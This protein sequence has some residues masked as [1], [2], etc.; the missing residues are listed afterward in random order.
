MKS[1]DAYIAKMKLQLDELNITIK[2][3]ELKAKLASI[4]TREKYDVEIVKMR[5][6]YQVAL[7]KL[8]ELKLSSEDAWKTM[9]AETEKVRDA[10]VKSYHYFKS[11][12]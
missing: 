12:L 7:D 6:Q 8:T 9:V 2:E 5:Q 10:L 11:Q 4:E 1:R 3:L